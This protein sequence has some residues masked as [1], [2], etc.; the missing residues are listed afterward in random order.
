MTR[1][2]EAFEDPPDVRVQ[3]GE[4]VILGTFVCAAYTPDA[5]EQLLRQLAAA[6][7][8][9]REQKRALESPT[10]HPSHLRLVP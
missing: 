3:D 10:P 8:L 4:V 9:A 2:L 5:A 1:H 6:I 7:Q